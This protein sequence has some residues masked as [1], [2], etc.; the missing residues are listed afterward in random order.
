MNYCAILL[1]GTKGDTMWAY[2]LESIKQSVKLAAHYGEW[3]I[4]K[5]VEVA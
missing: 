3:K 1:S 4:F 5:L 2:T